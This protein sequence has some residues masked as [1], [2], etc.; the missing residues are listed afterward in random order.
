MNSLAQQLD[1][2]EDTMPALHDKNLFL[3]MALILIQKKILL[4]HLCM[5]QYFMPAEYKSALK[6]I[7]FDGLPR[8]IQGINVCPQSIYQP[9]I[10]L[11]AL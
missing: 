5:K 10:P 4:I 7:Q 2:G 6:E 11:I 3:I 8:I 9:R 1:T